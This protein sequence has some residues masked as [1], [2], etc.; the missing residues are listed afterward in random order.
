MKTEKHIVSLVKYRSAS[1]SLQKALKLCGGLDRLKRHDRILVKPNLVISGPA[2]Q[3]PRGVVTSATLMHD[4]ITMLKEY[5]CGEISI[6]DGSLIVK[7]FGT[8]TQSAMDWSGMREVATRFGIKMVDFNKGPF[9]EFR[10]EG[11]KIRLSRVP[12]ETDFLINFPVLKTHAQTKVSLGIKNLKGCLSPGSK[13]AFHKHHLEELIAFLGNTIRA[14]LT[15]IDGLFGLQKGPLG[16]DAHPMDLIIAGKDPLSVDMVGSAV[17]GI[18]PVEVD[19][20]HYLGQ[21]QGRSLAIPDLDIRG[22]RIA[23]VKKN[24]IW[25]YPWTNELLAKYRIQGIRCDDPGNFF[26]SGCTI[27]AFAGLN[28]SFKENEGRGFEAIEVCMG[29]NKAHP[30]SKKVFL[31]GKCSVKANQ[32]IKGAVQIKGCPASANEI[33]QKFHENL[34]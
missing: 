32:D 13:K 23:S 15:I 33:Y 26:C 25:H 6:G 16:K 17:M 34:N 7:E 11:I 29:R 20:L 30:D 14:D 5:D 9:K 19:H 31:V 28:R 27:T 8:S 18:D 2:S 3:M 21:L 10:V 24:L 12:L 22:E 4:L 1:E